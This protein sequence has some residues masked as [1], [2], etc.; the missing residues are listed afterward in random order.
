MSQQGPI[1]VVSTRGAAAVRRVRSTRRSCFRSS[2]LSWAD[3]SRAVAQLRARRGVWS[4]RAKPPKP[5]STRSPRTDRGDKT[6]SAADRRRSHG[7]AARKRHSVFAQDG[8]DCDRL[9]A[10]LRAALRVQDAACDRDAPARRR[11]GGAD[12]A[13]RCRSRARR[14]RAADR[15]RR[16]LP[17]AFGFARRAHRAWSARSS[18]EAAAKHLNVPRHRRHRA[19]RGL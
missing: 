7:V 12:D 6:L 14:H 4:H 11:S 15:P 1:I 10:R 2:T 13:R 18:I 9:L 3:A 16:G 8:G 5:R 17:C 19:R